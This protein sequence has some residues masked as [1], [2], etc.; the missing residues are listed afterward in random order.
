MHSNKTLIND[1]KQ[2]IN[3]SENAKKQHSC[4]KFLKRHYQA[5]VP[6]IKCINL[7]TTPPL[8]ITQ[9]FQCFVKKKSISSTKWN[10][11]WRDEALMMFSPNVLPSSIYCS[12][13]SCRWYKRLKDWEKETTS[14][15]KDQFEANAEGDVLFS[16]RSLNFL[17]LHR[18][19]LHSAHCVVLSSLSSPQLGCASSWRSDPG[20]QWCFS[21][22]TGSRCSA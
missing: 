1:P 7:K 5:Q 21:G 11:R 3:A 9:K 19:A 16:N 2:F 17:S 15:S 10:P 20:F 18:L 6:Q 22:H 13:S 4:C 14:L 12:T 8:Y